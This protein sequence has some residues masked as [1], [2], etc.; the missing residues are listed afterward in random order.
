MERTEAQWSDLHRAY[1]RR[2]AAA[3]KAGVA[4]MK[5]ALQLL[6]RNLKRRCVIVGK[7]EPKKL[8]AC[9]AEHARLVE[10]WEAAKWRYEQMGKSEGD[11]IEME[12]CWTRVLIQEGRI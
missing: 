7:I 2:F 11:Q 12:K 5:P 6:P 1:K 10:A 9:D 8:D 3:K 4:F